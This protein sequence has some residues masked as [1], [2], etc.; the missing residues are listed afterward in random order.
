[1]CIFYIIFS[2]LHAVAIIYSYINENIHLNFYISI[3]L[4]LRIIL[5]M[6]NI[7]EK[8]TQEDYGSVLL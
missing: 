5:G 8:I 1:M 7:E 4:I 2:F 3:F 6:L